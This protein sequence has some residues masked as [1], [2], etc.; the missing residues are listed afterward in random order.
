M[1]RPDDALLTIRL[2]SSDHQMSWFQDGLTNDEIALVRA[3]I[4]IYRSGGH[5]F[6]PA[7]RVRELPVEDL[8]GA[9]ERRTFGAVSLP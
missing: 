9:L 7:D 5:Q 6:E 4:N 2:F 1:G 8:I 3:A